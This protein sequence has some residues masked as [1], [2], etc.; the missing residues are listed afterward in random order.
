MAPLGQ[1]TE[2]LRGLESYLN[3]RQKSE[4]PVTTG[5]SA[6]MQN[7]L[8]RFHQRLAIL[9]GRNKA[10]YPLEDKQLLS[11]IAGLAEH[12]AAVAEA[13]RMAATGQIV[14]EEPVAE[15]MEA[16]Q[17]P[18]QAADTVVI[19]DGSVLSIFLEESTE[20]L[21]R[22]DTLLNTWR[23]NLSDQKLVQNLQREIHTFKGGARMA[24]LEALG[25]PESLHG[26][27]TR[28]NCRQPYAGHGSCRAGSRRRLRPSEHLGRATAFRTHAR[29]RQRTDTF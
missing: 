15:P 4:S 27:V 12:E 5:A 17:E 28:A 26:N 11:D 21:E 19:E 14:T 22:C 1:E 7:C 3:D 25:Q 23:D 6:T 8:H 13:F 2:L 10:T 24:G 18:V 16:E 20:I 29:G 9:R